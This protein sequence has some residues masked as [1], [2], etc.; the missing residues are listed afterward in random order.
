MILLRSWC[1]LRGH[2]GTVRVCSPAHTDV[3]LLCSRCGYEK[4]DIVDVQYWHWPGLEVRLTK[5]G[6][7]YFHHPT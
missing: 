1:W 2:V 6:K 4:F 7:L 3:M 5:D